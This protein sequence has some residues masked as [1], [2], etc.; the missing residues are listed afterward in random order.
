MGYVAF[1]R[2]DGQDHLVLAVRGVLPRRAGRDRVAVVLFFL[3]LYLYFDRALYES[4]GQ[5]VSILA[6]WPFALSL[7]AS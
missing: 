3:T 6:G 1:L 5:E 4:G 2:D 7:L